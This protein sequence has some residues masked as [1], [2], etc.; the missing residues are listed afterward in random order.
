MPA[1]QVS[2]SPS[3]LEIGRPNIAARD[4]SDRFA[5]DVTGKVYGG[6]VTRSASFW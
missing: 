4:D 1:P 6:D 2:G 5:T 3:R